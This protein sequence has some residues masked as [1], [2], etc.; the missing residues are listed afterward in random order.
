MHLSKSLRNGVCA[1]LFGGAVV[2]N[3]GPSSA[4]GVFGDIFKVK[5]PPDTERS[6]LW[7]DAVETLVSIYCVDLRCEADTK[8]S[9]DFANLTLEDL[10]IPLGEFVEGT[11]ATIFVEEVT[12]RSSLEGD[13]RLNGFP[14]SATLD[15]NGITVS[16]EAIN[17]FTKAIFSDEPTTQR[18]VG[19][20]IAKERLLLKVDFDNEGGI[21]QITV[22]A[23]LLSGDMVEASL[24]VNLVDPVAQFLVKEE[25]SAAELKDLG[26]PALQGAI[27]FDSIDWE[28]LVKIPLNS[29]EVSL[30]EHSLL[31]KVFAPFLIEVRSEKERLFWENLSKLIAKIGQA[32]VGFPSIDAD[33]D[34]IVGAVGFYQNWRSEGGNLVSGI[35]VPDSNLAA[36]E[37]ATS[38]D[39]ETSGTCSME[40]T[41]VPLMIGGMGVALPYIKD[42][43]DT[44]LDPEGFKQLLASFENL[45]QEEAESLDL[46]G[47]FFR[48][49]SCEGAVLALS[50]TEG[51]NE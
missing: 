47:E 1:F 31:N 48:T 14:N 23:G 10:E 46:I 50:Y 22:G 25:V 18:L 7:F 49:M 51:R 41:F 17:E 12:F 24:S 5:T 28:N 4:Q 38:F 44:I 45:G 16:D 39:P 27:L 19:R 34:D 13:T 29:A 6:V 11:E 30:T 36:L 32:S 15:L 33:L 42:A 9:R 43:R 40:A 8:K 3:T 37:N 20:E 2:L 35:R 21:A 26:D